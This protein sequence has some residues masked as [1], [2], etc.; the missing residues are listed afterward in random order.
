[1]PLYVF[2]SEL[3]PEIRAN[4]VA[5]SIRVA[6]GELLNNFVVVVE[7]GS[8]KDIFRHPKEQRTRQFL[9]RILKNEEYV[10]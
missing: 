7:E 3:Q 1:M 9:S 4:D 2:P 10:I 6:G 5:R 8:A